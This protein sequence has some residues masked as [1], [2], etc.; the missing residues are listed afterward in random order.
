MLRSTPL[1]SSSTY[2]PEG[3]ACWLPR[4]ASLWRGRKGAFGAMGR[5]A[6]ECYVVDCVVPRSRMAEALERKK[7]PEA[8]A[9]KARFEKAWARADTPIHATCLCVPVGG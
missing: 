8:A 1:T 9:V 4:R 7:S 2:G 5:V 3:P 6:E